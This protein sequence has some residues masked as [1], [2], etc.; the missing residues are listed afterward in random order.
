MSTTWMSQLSIHL[1]NVLFFCSRT[2]WY[3]LRLPVSPGCY[4]SFSYW[5]RG[6]RRPSGRP[7]WR[8]AS[9]LRYLVLAW[10]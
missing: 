7:W 1:L 5:P 10:M 8:R 6:S 9:I 2:Q 4:T 3:L